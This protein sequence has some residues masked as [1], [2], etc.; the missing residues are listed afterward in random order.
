MMSQL[1]LKIEKTEKG[2]E[3]IL[4]VTPSKEAIQKFYDKAV[5]E[6]SQNIKVNGFR[7]GHMPASVVEQ[8]VGKTTVQ[9]HAFDLGLSEM[10]TAAVKQEKIEPISMPKIEIG[11]LEE[12]SFTATC[13]LMPEVKI[14]DLD[15]VK[16]SVK[17]PKVTEADLKEELENLQSQFINWSEVKRKAKKG[18]RVEIDFSGYDK[19][20]N[21][22]PNT[23]SKNYPLVLGSGVFIPG[24][25]ENVEGMKTGEEKSFEVTFPKDYHADSLKSAKVTFKV[26]ANLVEEPNK[27]ELNDD[28][29][30]ETLKKEQTLEEYKKDLKDKLLKNKKHELIHEAENEVFEK[31]LKAS[32]IE[33]S[34]ILV[35]EELKIIK[36]E[37]SGDLQ[38]RGQNFQAFE[39][40]LKEREGKT[41]EESYTEKALE[42]VKLRFIVDHIIKTKDIKVTEE[43]VNQEIQNKVAES[44][45]SI[46]KHVEEYYKQNPNAKAHLNQHLLMDKLISVFVDKK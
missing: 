17:E 5:K 15:K 12:M 11:S 37:I 24:F 32:D 14:K 46:K 33:I 36:D 6:I 18:D 44:D 29:I 21:L 16:I 8:Q 27:P 2:A 30:K 38:R 26:K 3:V 4:K 28:F 41:F 1:S 40:D 20:E 35:E 43:E 25:E 10:Y 7:K 13:P 19:D 42:R 31:L 39:A 45:D 9:A 23:E 22:I 34:D